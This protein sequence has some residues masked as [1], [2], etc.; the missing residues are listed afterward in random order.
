MVR[1][2]VL[3]FALATAAGACT[4]FD[5]D[6]PDDSCMSDN[7]CFRAQGEICN[8]QTKQCQLRPTDAGIDTP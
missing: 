1:W 3:I 6:P 7:D 2:L 8:Q 5:E 4:L